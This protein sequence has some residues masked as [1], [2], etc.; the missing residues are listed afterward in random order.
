MDIKRYDHDQ[1]WA[2]ATSSDRE[3]IFNSPPINITEKRQGVT[4]GRA[5][6]GNAQVTGQSTCAN[7]STLCMD[8]LADRA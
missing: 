8:I 1:R 6:D 3:P 4:I 7:P 2:M 5:L